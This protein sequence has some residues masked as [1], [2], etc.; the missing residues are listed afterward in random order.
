MI[1][2]SSEN[3]DDNINNYLENRQQ[4]IDDESTF[5]KR[6]KKAKLSWNGKSK[7]KFDKIR[8]KLRTMS[9]GIE[10]CNYCENNE[11]IDIEHIY[12]KSFFPKK[13]FVWENYILA[14]KKCNTHH[15]LD[16]FAV[17]KPANSSNVVK[18]VRGIK[19]PNTKSVFIDPR[20]ENGMDFMILD[21]KGRTFFFVPIEMEIDGSAVTIN[22]K[23]AEYTINLLQLNNRDALVRNR[24]KKAREFVSELQRYIQ[25]K[26]SNN[27]DELLQ[28]V[29]PLDIDDFDNEIPFNRHKTN[30]LNG[31][32]ENIRSSSHVT[33][34]EELKRQRE[35]LPN[36]NKLFKQEPNALKW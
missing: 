1:R 3:L 5:E 28:L 2:L 31:I 20:V 11:A 22:S 12:P 30:L 7:K 24:K 4:V 18:M 15:K 36:T 34:W 17:F 25:I 29:N 23:K 9:I 8:D 6:V 13:C 33:V 32:V 14:C 26:R 35:N 27:I 16:N 10:C 19:P 21:I